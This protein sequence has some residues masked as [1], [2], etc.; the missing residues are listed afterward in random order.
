MGAVKSLD[1]PGRRNMLLAAAALLLLFAA[2]PASGKTVYQ[3]DLD[4]CA[5]KAADI[6]EAKLGSHIG[7]LCSTWTMWWPGNE[8]RCCQTVLDYVGADGSLEY[9]LC[10]PAA[11]DLIR[12]KLSL[13]AIDA[14]S[15]PSKCLEYD[16]RIPLE[17]NDQCPPARPAPTPAP[18]PATTPSP[19]SQPDVP[20]GK[21]QEGQANSPEAPVATTPTQAQC[22][23][24][25]EEIG[26]SALVSSLASCFLGST[27]SCCGKATELLGVGGPL[28]YCVCDPESIGFITEE[29]EKFGIDV[30]GTLGGCLSK[31]YELPAEFNQYCPQ[32][33]D[34]SPQTQP[35]AGP[36]PAL[37]A[38]DVPPTGTPTA[39]DSVVR[40]DEVPQAAAGSPTAVSLEQCISKADEIGQEAIIVS[41]ASCLAGP[42]PECCAAALSLVG[43]G[44]PLEFCLCDDE[45]ARFITDQT[46]DLDFDLRGIL[47]GCLAEGVALPFFGNQHC[48]ASDA[49][50]AVQVVDLP[51][52]MVGLPSQSECTSKAE[53]MGEEALLSGLA[54]CLD[55]PSDAC[56]QAAEALAGAQGDL[57]FC[58]CRQ[59][60]LDDITSLADQMQLGVDLQGLAAGCQRL[61]MLSSGNCP[62]GAGNPLRS[63]SAGASQR[64][65]PATEF[66]IDNQELGNPS[67]APPPA[68]LTSGAGAPPTEDSSRG[69]PTSEQ[70]N[71]P[72]DATAS[73]ASASK[74]SMPGW[75]IVAI[76][77]AA[78]LLAMFSTLAIVLIVRRC[79]R[80]PADKR[81]GIVTEVQPA[82]GSQ[83]A[84]AS[85]QQKQASGKN[86][87]PEIHSVD[88]TAV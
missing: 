44:A 45:A 41:V 75:V 70:G 76:V 47:D 4:E 67:L 61:P 18:R 12:N 77:L 31:G 49:P 26:Q 48:A 13:L 82:I 43:A 28:E 3:P 58:L 87:A 52:D 17:N 1:S 39:N 73:S 6:G 21:P 57:A 11:A 24:A 7:S 2:V 8:R 78:L 79:I 50:T 74:N 37:A 80:R 71:A 34:G 63:V 25:A 53:G 40:G 19:P 55:G 35:T 14:D 46:D 83:A 85:G 56:C 54:P 29:A 64:L 30:V 32:A 42:I 59:G 23:A 81:C 68:A 38:P 16:V 22:V 27:D 5:S 36:S 62:I 33:A 88:V 66:S 15:L 86:A 20:D 69:A 84:G 65:P 51:E 9:C 10:D 72:A 60:V